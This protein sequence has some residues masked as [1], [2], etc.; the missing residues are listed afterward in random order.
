MGRGAQV[1]FSEAGVGV[2]LPSLKGKL[3]VTGSCVS[4]RGGGGPQERVAV[5]LTAPYVS[6]LL[7]GRSFTGS[8]PGCWWP[9]RTQSLSSSDSRSAG[10]DK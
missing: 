4:G 3:E 5:V 10:E 2:L 9:S 8:P 7:C 6:A 1:D